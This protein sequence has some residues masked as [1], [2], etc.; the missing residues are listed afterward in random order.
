MP[1]SPR[2]QPRDL[3]AETRVAQATTN[4][5]DDYLEALEASQGSSVLVDDAAYASGLAESLSPS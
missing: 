5:S 4:D 2:H 3:E 1:F